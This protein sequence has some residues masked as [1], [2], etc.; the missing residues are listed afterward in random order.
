M[1]RIVFKGSSME[2]LV[3]E[4]VDLPTFLSVCQEL[5]RGF[6]KLGFYN[7][8]FFFGHSCWFLF[9]GNCRWL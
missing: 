2:I 1:A 4:I 6:S 8:P 5:P 7:F 3:E 9:R